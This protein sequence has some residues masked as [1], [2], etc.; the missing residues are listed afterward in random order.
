MLFYAPGDLTVT[1]SG[2]AFVKES[3]LHAD[4][5]G[6]FVSAYSLDHSGII[7]FIGTL[8]YSAHC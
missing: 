7:S 1:K 5:S 3:N 2:S 8:I 4:P 6:W